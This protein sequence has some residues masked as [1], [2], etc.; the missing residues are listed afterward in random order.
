MMST[1]GLWFVLGSIAGAQETPTMTVED[2]S[3]D[4]LVAAPPPKAPEVSAARTVSV[5]YR[6]EFDLSIDE[7]LCKMTGFCDCVAEFSGTGTEVQRD[8]AR[9]TYEGSWTLE[10]GNCNASL[11]P[12]LPTDKRA[13]HTVNLGADGQT[14]EEWV[15]HSK[16]DNHQR[17]ASGPKE[18]GQYWIAEMASP[19][20]SATGA[21]VYSET[22]SQ[23]I[24]GVGMTTINSLRI[25]FEPAEL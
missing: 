8:G 13:F 12:W 25:T 1:V 20:D 14:V 18:A 7:S 6:L 24:Q 21:M 15:V 10:S 3:D 19:V 17:I 11:M 16:P 4:P 9:R 22:E 2:P 5:Q 23:G